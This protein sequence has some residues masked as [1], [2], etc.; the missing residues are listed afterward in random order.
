MCLTLRNNYKT[1]YNV[2]RF[3]WKIIFL[4]TDGQYTAPFMNWV[5]A[6]RGKYNT[7]IGKNEVTRFGFHVFLTRAEARRSKQTFKFYG[8]YPIKRVIVKGF[9]ASGTYFN[10]RSETWK[11]M[12]FL[13]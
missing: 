7:A 4:R 6:A 5:Y 12:K 1:P 8:R 2:S 9:L 13:D 10:G 11:Q 3:R